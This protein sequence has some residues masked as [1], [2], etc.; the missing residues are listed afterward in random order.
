[1]EVTAL[2]LSELEQLLD[3][4]PWFTLARKEYVRRHRAFGQEDLREAAAR[5]GIFVLSRS[6]FLAEI[7]GRRQEVAP[8]VAPVAPETA[9]DRVAVSERTAAPV[10]ASAPAVA[11]VVTAPSADAGLQ[12]AA[13]EEPSSEAASAPVQPRKVY[14]V[15]GDYFDKE[16]FKALGEAAAEIDSKLDFNPITATLESISAPA[17]PAPARQEAP[18]SSGLTASASSGPVAGSAEEPA[19]ETLARIYADQGLYDRAIAVYEKLILLDPEKSAYFAALI[20]KTNQ[21]K[22]Q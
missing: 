9:P 8:V 17:A 2:T 4:Y 18:V 19:S 22:Q 3:R 21:I 10:E 7:T 15:G 6:E 12:P 16:D 5:A 14:V 20:D 13:Q 1:M 11:S